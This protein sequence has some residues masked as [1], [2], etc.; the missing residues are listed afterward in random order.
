LATFLLPWSKPLASIWAADT[1]S[2]PG[3][4]GGGWPKGSVILGTDDRG[5]LLAAAESA[6]AAEMRDST[7]WYSPP[8]A[9]LLRKMCV[10]GGGRREGVSD[11]MH[12]WEFSFVQ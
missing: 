6:S 5:R 8:A 10:G 1:A 9:A 3:W 11:I 4:L 2:R 12:Q 7:T